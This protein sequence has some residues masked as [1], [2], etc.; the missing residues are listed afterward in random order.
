MHPTLC[1]SILVG[2]WT[3]PLFFFEI[4]HNFGTEKTII[5]KFFICM[6]LSSLVVLSL[7]LVF[8]AVVGSL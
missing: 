2:L 8:T 1:L 4:D 7:N 6:S 3:V 5:H